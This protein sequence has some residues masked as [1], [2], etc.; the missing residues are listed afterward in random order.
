MAKVSSLVALLCLLYSLLCVD[1]TEEIAQTPAAVDGQLCARGA[2]KA[3]LQKRAPDV[4]W[5][6]DNTHAEH[7]TRFNTLYASGNRIISISVYESPPNV[8]YAAVWVKRSR[9]DQVAIHG[10]NRAAF[11]TWLNSK[12]AAGYVATAVS[13][14]GPRNSEVYA[15]V[16]EKTSGL[17]WR[18]ISDLTASGFEAREVEQGKNKMILKS[19]IGYGTAADRRYCGLWHANPNYDK[20]SW[21]LSLGVGAYQSFFDVQTTK[22]YWHPV[23]VAP[24][25]DQSFSSVFSDTHIGDW[26][27]VHGATLQT[28]EAR[29]N[30]YKGQGLAL[31]TLQGGG[32]GPAARFAAIWAAT[33]IPTPRSFS[34]VGPISGFRSPTVAD[35]L[36]ATIQSF[37]QANGVRQAQLAI[38]KNGNIRMDRAYSWNEQPFRRLTSPSD[39]FLLASVSKMYV[40]AAIQALYNSGKLSPSTLVHPLL[41][42]SQP[43]DARSDSITVKHLVDHAGGYDRGNPEVPATYFDPVF[44]MRMIANV[45]GLLGA[46]AS[47]QDMVDYMYKKRPLQFTPGTMSGVYSN[48]G[49]L[50]L[51]RV[52]EKVTGKDYYDY[53]KTAVLTCPGCSQVY[54]W[55]SSANDHRNDKV[56]QESY[57]TGPSAA[58]PTAALSVAAVFS[59][60]GLYKES[61]VGPS[62]LAASASTLV[63]FVQT[64]AAYGIGGRRNTARLGSMPGT[65]S[66]V[67]SRADNVNFAVLVNTR[68]WAPNTTAYATW[69]KLVKVDIP[70]LLNQN[71]L[72]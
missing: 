3:R 10:A 19:V 71:P 56:T 59:G 11:D 52:V 29:N 49:Y 51:S 34:K 4:T 35:A 6:A 13:V 63:N 44:Q 67:E 62:S 65:S 70:S 14:T 15:A 40:T 48:Y 16:M 55:T 7:Q 57:E 17:A 30:Q 26:Q 12:G 23:H 31:I 24:S 46:P 33:D 68:D 9:P 45:Q 53:L 32:T 27:T 66:W 18:L 8:R 25:E 41:G 37:M 47:K 28:I 22:P 1:G 2:G 5:Y 20:S 64:H 61:C 58:N 21:W 36:D 39:T 38:S 50:L 69:D 72:S 54:L 60:D 43:F 42:L